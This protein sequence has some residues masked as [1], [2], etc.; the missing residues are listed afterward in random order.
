MFPFNVNVPAIKIVSTIECLE[1][2]DE[3]YMLKL[4]NLENKYYYYII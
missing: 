1:E 3:E 2:A 4:S